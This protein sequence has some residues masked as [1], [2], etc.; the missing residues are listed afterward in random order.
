MRDTILTSAVRVTEARR[1]AVS[2]MR[3]ACIVV[4]PL[5]C[6]LFLQPISCSRNHNAIV[7][8]CI[9]EGNI[10]AQISVTHFISPPTCHT[11]NTY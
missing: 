3:K 11:L 9:K 8:I 4:L 10:A 1:I 2:I 6:F 5:R 7:F